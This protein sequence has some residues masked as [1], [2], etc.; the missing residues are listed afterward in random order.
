MSA[1]LAPAPGRLQ[2]C[3]AAPA[4]AFVDKA[5]RARTMRDGDSIRPLASNLVAGTPSVILG[6]PGPTRLDRETAHRQ[7]SFRS[8]SAGDL[9][10]DAGRLDLG[11]D[12]RIRRLVGDERVDL[13]EIA[14]LGH[15]DLAELGSVGHDH[16]AT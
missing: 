7:Q 14:H 11:D 13:T 4:P 9:D 10:G 16:A 6:A 15:L 1:F 8:I 3:T 5:P 2:L 12:G